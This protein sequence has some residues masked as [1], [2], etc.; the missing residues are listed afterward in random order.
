MS[1]NTERLIVELSAKVDDYNRK[2]E[3][4]MAKTETGSRRGAA[5]LKN[6]EDR[7]TSLDRIGG[8]A[9][10]RFGQL[11][12][13]YFSVRTVAALRDYADEYTNLTNQIKTVQ[14]PTENLRETMTRLMQ[15]AADTRSSMEATTTLYSRLA[16]STE[17]LGLSQTDL[18]DLTQTLNKSFAISGATADEAKNAIIQLSQG[19]ASGAL[20]GDEFNS[21]AEQA[22]IIMEALTK[23]LNMNRGELRELAAQ[24]GITTKILIDGIMAY[25]TVIDTDFSK[26]TGTIVSSMGKVNDAF[27]EF[28][29][30]LN[31]ASG[32]GNYLSESIDG[33]AEALREAN[34]DLDDNEETL[35]GFG[36]TMM[37]FAGVADVVAEALKGM[38]TAGGQDTFGDALA[39]AI[40]KADA[41][42]RK[43]KGLRDGAQAPA[44][45]DLGMGP[46]L[47][48][49]GYVDPDLTKQMGRDLGQTFAESFEEGILSGME[50]KSPLELDP[51]KVRES[52]LANLRAKMD[53]EFEFQALVAEMQDSGLEREQEIAD[54]KAAI[55]ERLNKKLKAI[56]DGD[57]KQE[58][59]AANKKKGL[60]REGFAFASTIAAG[61]AANSEKGALA[62]F[63]IRQGLALSETFMSTKS[64]AMKA[65]EELGPIAGP[66]AAVAIG[67]LGAASMASIASA[68]PSGGAGSTQSAGLGTVPSISTQDLPDNT[69]SLDFNLASDT[70]VNSTQFMIT[71]PPGDTIGEMLAEWINEGIKKGRIG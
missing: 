5:A 49:I 2:I 71:A 18:L 42:D 40:E 23:S 65:Y 29:G 30:L 32:A 25:K 11:A 9:L 38:F 55:A 61:L 17:D 51:E 70:G 33:V 54:E 3:S 31:D 21:V 8:A 69:G 39:G 46:S 43:M 52:A 45:A 60:Q 53:A 24:G 26:T 13:A 34:K 19:L 36:E 50:G 12:A 67:A 28:V 63:R 62:S 57:L 14:K 7:T 68:S 27:R 41:L 16:R 47:N 15:V 56:I 35:G 4:S 64:A 20:R 59:D 44:G 22:P 10:V 48:G 6:V 1:T 37:A 66:V 58:K